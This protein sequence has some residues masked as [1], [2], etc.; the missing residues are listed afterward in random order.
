MDRDYVK[1]VEQWLG[2]Y[3]RLKRDIARTRLQLSELSSQKAECCDG[4][5]SNGQK[6]VCVQTSGRKDPVVKAVEMLVD[7]YAARIT[8]LARTL[9]EANRQLSVIEQAVDAAELS[10]REREFIKLRYFDGK[11]LIT[12]CFQLYCSEST[13]WRTK[14]SALEKLKGFERLCVA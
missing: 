8:E 14:N 2:G 4:L 3:R 5:L 7:V 9:S 6:E 12:I 10:E 1:T 11:D 13:L